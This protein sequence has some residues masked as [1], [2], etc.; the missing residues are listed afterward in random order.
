MR[1][2]Y[3]SDSKL[4]MHS[5]FQETMCLVKHF[6]RRL[7]VRLNIIT[8]LF[9]LSHKFQAVFSACTKI[10]QLA[11]L[12]LLL[13]FFKPTSTKPQAEKTRLDILNY[14]CNGNLLC[15]HGVVERNRI[16]IAIT[17]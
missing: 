15:Y 11:G 17:S 3:D 6:F 10:I 4:N 5:A 7:T 1:S 8:A 12:L 13:L 2:T 9:Q 14:G 16:Y